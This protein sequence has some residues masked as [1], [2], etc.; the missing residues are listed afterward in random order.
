MIPLSFAQQRLWFLRQFEG[1]SAAYNLPAAFRIV[2]ALDADVLERALGDVTARHESLRTI[3]REVDGEPFQIVLDADAAAVALHRT[4]CSP[5]RLGSTLR[6]EVSHV[7]DLSAELPLRATLVTVAPQEHVLLLLMHHIASDGTSLGPLARDVSTAYRARYDEREP[8]WAPLPV[9]YADYVLWQRELLS[10]EDD[11]DS[12]VN[13][14]LGF[15]KAAL[16]GLPEELNHPTDRPRPVATDHRGDSV[17]FELPAEPHHRIAELARS[18]GT[19]T[20]MVVQAA[21]ATLLTKLGAGTDIPV[22]APV[23]GRTDEALDELVGLFV[24]TLVLRTDTSNNPTFLELLERVRETDLAA[25][26]HQDVPFERV[27]EAVNPQ[28]VLARHPLFQVFL[29]LRSDSDSALELPGL[30]TAPVPTPLEFSR[31]DLSFDLEEQY[32]PD[33]HPAGIKGVLRYST[34]LFDRTTVE[35]CAARL[36]RIL[37]AAV[38]TP[39]QRLDRLDILEPAERD[40]LLEKWNGTT[41]EATGLLTQDLVRERAAATPDRVA[42]ISAG[43]EMTYGELD[44]RANRL[45]HEL[46]RRGAGPE[47]LVGIVVPRS[48]DLVVTM[49]AVLKSG[50]AYVPIDPGFPADR[51][52]HILR[53]TRSVCTVTT[54]AVPDTLFAGSSTPRLLVDRGPTAPHPDGPTDDDLRALP[55]PGHPAYVIFTSGSTGR[56]KGVVVPHTALTNFLSAMR[57]QVRLTP[58]DRLL[59]VTTVSFDIA[60]LEIYLPLIS[61]ATVVLADD[62]TVRDPQALRALAATGRAT[63][64]QGTPSLWGTL[65]GKDDAVFRGLHMLV[66]GEALP[67]SLAETMA[68]RG[69]RITNLYGPT[70][71]TIWSTS[72]EVTAETADAPLIGTPILNTRVYVLDDLLSPVPPGVVGDLYI[73]GDGVARGYLHDPGRTAERFVADPF[74]AAGSRM[75][76]TGDRVSWTEA[77]SLDYVGRTDEQVKIRGYRIELGEIEAVMLRHPLVA[78]AVAMVREDQPGDKRLIGYVV[79]EPGAGAP[80]VEQ[81]RAHTSA[82]LPEY[83]VPSTYVVLDALP[84]TP[85]GKLNR[86]QLPAPV[87]AGEA[88][89]RGPRSPQEEILCGL[90]AEV[91]SVPSAG[92]DDSFFDLGG[93]SLL[94]AR[95]ISRVRSVLGVE[96]PIRALF[97]TPTPGRLAG[98]LIHTRTA[99]PALVRTERSSRI[100]LSFAQQR[101]WFLGQFEGP[102]STYNVPVAFRIAGEPDTDALQRAL[103]D[104]VT[105]HES[106]RTVFRKVDGVPVQIVLPEESTQVTLHRSRCTAEG[107]DT[108]LRE[109]GRHAFDLSAELPLRATLFTSAPDE[110]VLL[111]LMHHIASDGSSLQPLAR[112]L[113]SAYAARLRGHEPRWKPLPVQYADYTLWQRAML[114]AESDP[115]SVLSTQL[116]YWQTALKGLPGELDYPTDR[117]RPSV[118]THRGDSAHFELAPELH[119]ALVHLA[120][121]TGTTLFMVVQAALATVLTKLGAGTDIPIGTPVGGRTDEALDLLI[122]FFV[123]TLVLRTDTS[124]DPTFLE[125]LERVRTTNLA[126]YSNQDVPFERVVE[127][128]NPQRS[129]ARHPLFQVLLEVGDSEQ[130]D[131]ELDGLTVRETAAELRVAKFDL[132]VNFTAVSTGE[133]LPGGLHAD[134]EYAL[135]L[136]D[137]ESVERLFARVVRVLEAAAVDAAAPTRL[138][139]VL[140]PQ[141]RT[142]LLE[143]WSG[144]APAAMTGAGSVQ[145]AFAESLARSPDEVAVR[146]GG[147]GLSY[148]ELDERANRLAHRLLALGVGRE[149]PV[150]VLTERSA[151]VVVAFLAVLKAGAFYVPLHSG[152]PRERMEWIVQES[153]ARVL[154]ADR[155]MR[156]RGLPSVDTVVITDEEDLGAL[157]GWDPQ[158]TASPEQLAYVMYTS[159]STGEPKGVAVTHQDVLQ[160]A[161]D[162][163]FA[164]EA[165]RR[166]LLIASYAFDP[167]T[168]A[169]WVPLLAGGTVVLAPDGEVS[170]AELGRL[171]REEQITGLDVTA[172][173]FRVVA[174]ED[175]ACFAG[176][177]EVITGGDV[178][179]PGAVQRVLEHCPD[180]VVR[181]AYGPTETTFCATQSPWT[182]ADQV[183]APLPIGRPLDGMHAYILDEHLTP[184]PPG[185][186]GELYLAGTGLARGYWQRPA[187]T[188]ERFTADPFG[189]PGTRMYRTG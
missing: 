19:T 39:E 71:T 69:T 2:G 18:T 59:A 129:L 85:N 138:I 123:N 5:N 149:E 143:R 141:E 135:D 36:T 62:S 152:Y 92:V 160:L 28:R 27:V 68:A 167:S 107:L 98:Q 52:R 66:G 47:Q 21:L 154:L 182:H 61:G 38:A 84:L 170:V 57:E 113:S 33:G 127:G 25:Y 163:M 146:C 122:G 137:R 77:G 10:S 130:L 79:A 117:P 99:R 49:L 177:R 144:K 90:F 134:I 106:L 78:Q 102:G 165:H 73:A 46:I 108:A 11:P 29:S 32:G 120:R 188:A 140:E 87:Y 16:Q 55:R 142:D 156:A 60:A 105:R 125:L 175:P 17:P 95:L 67:P 181:A 173:L 58:D 159:G 148:R 189:P 115:G 23:A 8:E 93:H 82:L 9:Q 161:G 166:V 184:L 1:P 100:P 174:E 53:Q 75:Y 150:A 133:G 74:G 89:S 186:T 180:T 131:L 128:V 20:F 13:E 88:N 96:L 109:A 101:L 81:L 24:N 111:L 30:T 15:W 132:A 34:E 80:D 116:E 112:D 172:G 103:G 50:A 63:V 162:S 35:T 83:M 157:P 22:G 40:V 54:S 155:E 119:G 176:V 168:Y 178:N 151:D 171:I 187:L 51:V 44:A 65:L 91:L 4:S 169:V 37:D 94:A 6:Q 7:F 41:A 145:G 158:V 12:L 124:G 104:V 48:L 118:A 136:F 14:Q 114:G 147:Q 97:D 110:H 139:D 72:A 26:S 185:T 45:A 86:R 70:E 64:M 31:F 183:P 56:P 42:V 126:A 153:G 164:S 121:S 43:V 179:A 3:F 76:H